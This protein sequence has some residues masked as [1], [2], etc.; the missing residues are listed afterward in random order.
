[1]SSSKFASSGAA[2]ESLIAPAK[3][4]ST[5]LVKQLKCELVFFIPRTVC[6]VTVVER[7]LYDD[8]PGTWRPFMVVY[9]N[10]PNKNGNTT[11]CH[12][13]ASYRLT[14]CVPSTTAVALLH[15]ARDL[16][17]RPISCR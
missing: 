10:P 16:A 11:P 12:N 1:M 3:N 15:L 7:I 6:I 14:E 5:T 17:S 8:D 2:G 13:H 4:W 9:E